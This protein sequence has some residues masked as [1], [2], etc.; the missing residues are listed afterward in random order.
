MEHIGKMAF[1]QICPGPRL[2]RQNQVKNTLIRFWC[3]PL[4]LCVQV[5]EPFIWQLTMLGLNR[6]E[7]SIAKYERSYGIRMVDDWYTI[8]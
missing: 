2:S 1:I 3:E 8:P 6:T 7:A 5:D 4:V